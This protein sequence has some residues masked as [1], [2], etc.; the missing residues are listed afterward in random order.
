[1]WMGCKDTQASQVDIYV[2]VGQTG[3]QIAQEALS[4]AARFALPSAEGPLAIKTAGGIALGTGLTPTRTAGEETAL[5]FQ[6]ATGATGAAAAELLKISRGAL[7]QTQGESEKF[8]AGVA[9]AAEA[10]DIDP[11]GFANVFSR[12]GNLFVV[13]KVDLGRGIGLLGALSVSAAGRPERVATGAERVLRLSLIDN[14]FIRDAITKGG[15]DPD[16]TN[17]LDKADALINFMAQDPR[18]AQR[19]K[20]EGQVPGELIQTLQ[21]IS[22]PG[23]KAKAAAV[24]KAFRDTGVSFLTGKLQGKLGQQTTQEQG[25]ALREEA[26]ALAGL[27][28]GSVGEAEF[29]R[30]QIAGRFAEA[31][32]AER[33][34]RLVEFGITT[35]EAQGGEIF[36]DEPFTTEQR[37][38]LFSLNEMYPRIRSTLKAIIEAEGGR[39][40]AEKGRAVARDLDDS[41][42]AA[43]TPHF[44][45]EQ[46]AFL[47]RY[48]AAMIRAIQFIRRAGRGDV[49][50][51]K[52]ITGGLAER[53]RRRASFAGRIAAG[54]TEVDGV[55][56]APS[57][58]IQ[59]NNFSGGPDS[60]AL[61]NTPKATTQ[62][63]Q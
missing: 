29:V 15:G 35:N 2:T 21:Q 13:N 34:N 14:Q 12:V 25:T 41:R 22:T 5:L 27:V 53:V 62:P 56:Q 1:M 63:S 17:P 43:N 58:Q 50:G 6:G 57:I 48:K 52:P 7:Q 54:A 20:D 9:G 24:S 36:G 42:E 37:D 40:I 30:K 11:G 19:L 55:L 10:S 49:V 28:P 38:L 44:I 46:V 23:A 32:G 33:Q 59:V 39:F 26:A 47:P 16:S 61:T 45:G 8:F 51:R 31:G 18:N 4:R 60:R 3:L